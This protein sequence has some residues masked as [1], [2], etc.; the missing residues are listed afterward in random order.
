MI[1]NVS[2]TKRTG[3][4]DLYFNYTYWFKKPRT[5]RVFIIVRISYCSQYGGD[6]ASED[7]EEHNILRLKLHLFEDG[8]DLLV[9]VGVILLNNG[10]RREHVLP[11]EVSSQTIDDN[12]HSLV[13]TRHSC[14]L[15]V[16]VRVPKEV[17]IGDTKEV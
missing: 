15:S 13:T 5:C 6:R 14:G 3:K 12:D 17:K 4:F 9:V 2:V 16:S 10:C 7:V 11:L 8:E 1:V